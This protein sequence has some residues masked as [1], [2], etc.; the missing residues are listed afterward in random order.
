MQVDG[1]VNSFLAQKFLPSSL[2]SPADVARLEAVP[3]QV[4]E[5]GRDQDLV[6]EGEHSPQCIVLLDGFACRYRSLSDG[7][8]QIVSFHVPGDFLDLQGFL[9]DR[10][11]HGIGTLT[12]SRIG[13]IAHS[14]IQEL[15]ESPAITRLLWRETVIDGAIHREWLVNVGRR[16][17]YQRVAHV[18][19]E[20]VTRL[21]AAGLGDDG[22]CDLPL[23]Q[24]ELADAT[25]LSTVHVNRV[26]QELRRDG[27]ITLRGRVFRALDWAGLMRAAEVDPKYLKLLSTRRRIVIGGDLFSR[28]RVDGRAMPDG[29]GI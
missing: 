22:V 12:P 5:V 23:T 27:L 7:R 15:L 10:L 20:L 21:Q 4:R 29:K 25:G 17:A 11:D 24:S 14:S 1:Q 18:F 8:R 9:L 13:L 3:M 26:I 28:S 19:C 2:L 16:T 6:R